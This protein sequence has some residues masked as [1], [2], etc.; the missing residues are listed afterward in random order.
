METT[1]DS[2]DDEKIQGNRSGRQTALKNCGQR[3]VA[4]YKRQWQKP[5]QRKRNA[6]GQ[7][8]CLN[9]VLQIAEKRSKRQE[10]KGKA[11]PTEF[12]ISENSKER[13]KT[14]YRKNNLL[15]WAMQ[16]NREKQ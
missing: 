14:K 15:K 6:R 4:L 13:L 5:T 8:G 12:R 16:R 7:S 3:L 11:N 1:F 10:R 2:G 9:E